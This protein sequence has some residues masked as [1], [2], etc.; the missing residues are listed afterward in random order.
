VRAVFDLSVSDN[1][2]APSLPMQFPVLSENA[3]NNKS[4]TLETE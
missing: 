2:I 4:V 3:M 1:L